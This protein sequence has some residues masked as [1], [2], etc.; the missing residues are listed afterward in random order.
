MSL[1]AKLLALFLLLAVVPLLALGGVEY[2]RSL[3]ALQALIAAQ[4][5][6]VAQ[7]VAQTI[8]SRAALLRSDLLLLAENSETQRWLA[9][10]ATEPRDSAVDP[11]ADQF[12]REVWTRISASY[13]GLAYRDPKDRVI[14]QLGNSGTPSRDLLDPVSEPIR[15]PQSGVV[16]GSVVLSPLQ[17]AAF[18][19]EILASGFGQ[20]GYGMVVDRERSRVLYHPTRATSGAELAP[21][22]AAE[23]WEIDRPALARPTGTFR[24]HAGDTV[25]VASFASLASPPWTVVVSSAES[26]FAGPFTAVRRW[27]L[28][29]FIAVALAAALGFRHLLRRTMRSLED[30]TAA[31][32]V[33]G[34][35]EFAPTLPQARHDEV[36]RLTTSFETMVGKIREMVSQIE[37]SRQMAVLGEFAAHLS[38]E[39]RNPLTS[40][41]LNLQKLEREGREGRLP[42]ST[43]KPLEISL[44]EVARLDAVVRGVLDLARLRPRETAACSLRHLAEETIETLAG[45]AESQGVK[46]ERAFI[47]AHDRV[48]VDPSQLKGA[49]LNLALNALDAMPNG[50]TLQLVT[51]HQNGRIQLRLADSGAGI[52]SAARAEIF[53]PFFTTKPSGTGLGLSLAQ[54]AIEDNGGTLLLAPEGPGGGA[55]FVIDLPLSGVT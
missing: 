14:Y 49:L 4:N 45:Q 54:R 6:R 52:P 7:R 16:L 18:P 33:V 15:D 11:A 55:E 34:R 29:L 24:Y 27:T 10:R 28:L 36:G 13:D 41:K 35:G 25:R 46:I 32:A 38:H 53:R 40:I 44:R 19:L 50:G 42:E 2:A 3:R 9:H 30:L 26:E 39:I 37:S 1:R 20:T 12:L 8:E 5:A 48:E 23:A 47:T 22:I 51:Q 31:T 21:L 43:G 17:A